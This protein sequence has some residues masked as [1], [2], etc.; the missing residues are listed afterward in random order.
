MREQLPHEVRDNRA[1]PENPLHRK[2][3]DRQRRICQI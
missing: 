3:A 1:L 2:T